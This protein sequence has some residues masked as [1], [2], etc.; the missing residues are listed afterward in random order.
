MFLFIMCPHPDD[1]D[2]AFFVVNLVDEPVLDIDASGICAGEVADEFFIRRRVLKRVFFKNFEDG[3]GLGLEP[4][5]GEFYCVLPGISG[6]GQPPFY[7][8]R[9]FEHFAG[10]VF[11]PFLM[12]SRMPG[13]ESR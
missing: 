1:F 11:R 7:H 13:M 8:L 4:C 3:F 6:E 10:G 12:D 9:P 5:G 2:D